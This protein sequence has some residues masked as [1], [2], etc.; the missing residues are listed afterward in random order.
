[1]HQYRP[2]LTLMTV[3]EQSSIFS[4][5][6]HLVFCQVEAVITCRFYRLPPM[7]LDREGCRFGSDF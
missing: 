5:N 4:V 2:I 7:D 6:F 1:M 3:Q